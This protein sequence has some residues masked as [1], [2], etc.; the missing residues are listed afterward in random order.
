[1]TSQE[2]AEYRVKRTNL[3]KALAGSRNMCKI[4]KGQELEFEQKILAELLKME[5]GDVT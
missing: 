2:E 5:G 3:S 1:M 4:L